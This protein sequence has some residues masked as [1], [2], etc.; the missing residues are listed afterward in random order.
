MDFLQAFE[1]LIGHEG[2]YSNHREDPGG[3]TMF[4][5]TA[6]VARQQGY[7]GEMRSLPLATA[8]AIYKKMYWD[9][10]RADEMPEPVRFH[11]FDAAVNSGAKQ[12]IRWLQR[13]VDVVDDGV[14]GP[15]TMQS[16]A[17]ANPY[18]A[19]MAMIGERLDMMTSL[20]TWGAF[21]RGWARR[22]A[23]NLKEAA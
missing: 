20:P 18:K 10:V 2:G 11:L 9:A 13:A 8:Q 4:G 22:I 23:D 3:E 1:K 7:G 21:S 12:S 17:A 19:A 16:V 14:L 15:M 6:R 5:I